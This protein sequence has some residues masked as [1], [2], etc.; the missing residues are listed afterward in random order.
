LNEKRGGTNF[1]TISNP[2]LQ[3]LIDGKTPGIAIRPLGAVNASF[4]A[5]E[6]QH[7]KF[8][9]KLHFNVDENSNDE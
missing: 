9:A 3:R 7:G 5:M 4:C 6:Y 1:I 2:V 8:G